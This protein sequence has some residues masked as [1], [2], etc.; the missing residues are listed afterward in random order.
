[1][2]KDRGEKRPCPHTLSGPKGEK[3]Q[4]Q[5]DGNPETWKRGYQLASSGL[6]PRMRQAQSKSSLSLTFTPTPTEP[7]GPL[8]LPH[9]ASAPRSTYLVAPHTGDLS[10]AEPVVP[11]CVQILARQSRR[12]PL[13]SDSPLPSVSK[14]RVDDWLCTSACPASEEVVSKSLPPLQG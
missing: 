11:H 9:H 14:G 12:K 8:V 13:R 4:R 7:P 6:Q 2:R 10:S 1:M 3:T 5:K